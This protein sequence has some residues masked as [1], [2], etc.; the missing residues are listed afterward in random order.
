[1]AIKKK[2]KGSAKGKGVK[3]GS[4]TKLG[5]PGGSIK[6]SSDPII[7]DLSI[8]DNNQVSINAP[9]ITGTS[10][11]V[12][13]SQMIQT[14]GP[15]MQQ[16]LS[17]SSPSNISVQPPAPAVSPEPLVGLIDQK[18]NREIDIPQ[19]IY[20]LIRLPDTNDFKPYRDTSYYTQLIGYDYKSDKWPDLHFGGADS[21]LIKV[22]V[23]G[24]D[25]GKIA[26]EY[27][28]KDQIDTYTASDIKGSPAIVKIDTGKILKDLGYRRGRFTVKFEFLRLSA[29][30]PFPVLVNGK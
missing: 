26:T 28:T 19:D 30:G 11:T 9:K 8:Q 6:Q 20:D 27:L 10:P 5:S 1:M 13:P 4:T 14:G 12:S 24:N 2:K 18:A 17:N 16:S 3:K 21:D 25:G 22:C 29:G 7:S 23:Y 15:A